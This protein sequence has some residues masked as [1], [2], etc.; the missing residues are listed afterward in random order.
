MYRRRPDYLWAWVIGLVVLAII[1]SIPIIHSYTQ[2]HTKTVTICSKE[3]VAKESGH[4]Y[5]VYTD[6]GTYRVSDTFIGGAR[7]KSADFYARLREGKTY[8]IDYY[9]WRVGFTSSFPNIRHAT[10]A[11]IQTPEAC[12]SETVG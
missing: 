9:G 12:D 4:E 8:V 3:S 7:F 11:Q 2:Q 5:R 6:Q 10:L 1:V